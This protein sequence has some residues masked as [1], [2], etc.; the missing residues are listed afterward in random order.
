LSSLRAVAFS[1][2]C[3]C[4]NE[5]IRP[6]IGEFHPVGT[7]TGAR[8]VSTMLSS[9]TPLILAVALSSLPN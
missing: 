4:L 6:K 2:T 8:R 9:V 3:W 7:G 1:A 5:K